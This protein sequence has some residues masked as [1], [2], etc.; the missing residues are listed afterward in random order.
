MTIGDAV[1]RALLTDN[2]FQLRAEASLGYTNGW[3]SAPGSWFEFQLMASE[4]ACVM[5]SSNTDYTLLTHGRS[6]EV[7][8]A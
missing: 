5:M 4:P 1:F 7:R 6:I 2:M 8:G 3:T